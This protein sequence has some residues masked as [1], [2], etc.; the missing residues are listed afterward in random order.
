MDRF[1]VWPE[2]LINWDHPRKNWD[3]AETCVLKP[4]DLFGIIFGTASSG[5]QF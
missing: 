3:H 1:K 4:P 5:H 2:M